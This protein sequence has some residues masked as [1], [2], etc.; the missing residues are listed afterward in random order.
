MSP[1]EM[2]TVRW[3]FY[4]IAAEESVTLPLNPNQM[5]GTKKPRNLTWA[6]GARRGLDRPRGI[7]LSADSPHEITFGGVVFTEEHYLLLL[8][9]IKRVTVIRITDHLG[10]SFEVL[11]QKF[12]P[13]ERLPT[14]RRPWRVDYTMSCLL[15]REVSV[16][17]LAPISESGSALPVTPA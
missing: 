10:R 5:S 7:D 2:A 3:K 13:V 8:N 6:Q 16:V 11:L 4:D 1:T 12:D 17:E 9:W 15:L 14:A